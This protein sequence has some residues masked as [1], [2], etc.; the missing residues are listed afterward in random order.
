[1]YSLVEDL[2]HSSSGNLAGSFGDFHPEEFWMFTP[3][4]EA[5]KGFYWKTKRCRGSEA[6]REITKHQVHFSFLP[7]YR[8]I[9]DSVLDPYD[10][11][12]CPQNVFYYDEM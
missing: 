6:C 12:I 11:A 8:N 3:Y 1:M 9:D 5:D 10:G 4:Y 2:E 7:P